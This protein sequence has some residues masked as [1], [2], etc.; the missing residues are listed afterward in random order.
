LTDADDCIVDIIHQYTVENIGQLC[1]DINSITITNND[2][3]RYNIPLTFLSYDERNFC[4]GELLVIPQ[5]LESINICNLV[6]TEQTFDIGVNGGVDPNHKGTASLELTG[7]VNLTPPAMSPLPRIACRG[8][9]NKMI[10]NYSA[11]TCGKSQHSQ[12][13]SSRRKLPETR[14]LHGKGK[15]KKKHRE[16]NNNHFSSHAHFRCIDYCDSN[17]KDPW[18]VIKSTDGSETYFQGEVNEGEN[19]LVNGYN[20]NGIGSSMN[21]KIYDNDSGSLKLIQEFTFD[22]SCSQNLFLGDI[23]GSLRLVGF[24]DSVR[25]SVGRN[26]C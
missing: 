15:G 18:I 17:D 25:G 20:R 2:N 3:D 26:D 23:F 19:F 8:Q 24:N 4:P 1:E 10:F 16:S 22:T 11:R 13:E 6:G 7:N 14:N 5:E 9:L 12:S 21:V